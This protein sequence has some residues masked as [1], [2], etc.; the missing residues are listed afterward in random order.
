MPPLPSLSADLLQAASVGPGWQAGGLLTQ[1][2]SIPMTPCASALWA[3]DE[4]R[5]YPAHSQ[6]NFGAVV[7]GGVPLWSNG[8]TLGAPASDP[9]AGASLSEAI[10]QAAKPDFERLLSTLASCP[11]LFS[12]Y[13]AGTDPQ[14]NDPLEM[15]PV[16]PFSFGTQSAAYAVTQLRGDVTW[17]VG[18]VTNGTDY[19]CL[20]FAHNRNYAAALSQFEQLAGKAVSKM[21]AG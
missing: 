13:P 6:E 10:G 9:D 8:I 14:G 18:Y 3:I 15:L 21:S 11:K 2:A 19:A 17:Y 4:Q 16:T 20:L 1:N 12:F 5:N 7:N